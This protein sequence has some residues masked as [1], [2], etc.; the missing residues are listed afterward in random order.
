MVQHAIKAEEIVKHQDH[1]LAA[2]KSS[3]TPNSGDRSKP[4]QEVKVKWPICF[5]CRE[6]AVICL[7]NV[8]KTFD[9]PTTLVTD[10]EE[11]GDNDM[12]EPHEK[13]LMETGKK[14][15]IRLSLELK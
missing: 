14:D 11:I 8:C 6:K 7:F 4:S 13:R 9:Y 15:L 1:K 5:H 10:E 3:L 12:E 2:L